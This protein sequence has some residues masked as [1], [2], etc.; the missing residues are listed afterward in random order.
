MELKTLHTY[1]YSHIY[2][3]VYTDTPSITMNVHLLIYIYNILYIYKLYI[4]MESMHMKIPSC[5]PPPG[6]RSQQYPQSLQKRTGKSCY[7]QL[8]NVDVHQILAQH[9]S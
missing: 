6:K 8:S 1:K 3:Y 2:I 4:Y 7:H 5:L 9:I